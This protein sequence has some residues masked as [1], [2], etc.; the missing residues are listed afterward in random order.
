MTHDEVIARLVADRAVFD[1]KVGA[2]L[3]ERLSDEPQGHDHSPRD[4]VFHVGAYEELIVE[5]LRSARMGETTVLDRDRDGWEAFNDRV[6]AE[7]AEADPADMLDRSRV[8]FG[9]LLQEVR[10]LSDAELVEVTGITEHI[11]PAWLDG[12]TLAELIALD[13][14][15]HYRMHY[16]ALEAAATG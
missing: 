14:F 16:A 7:A 15:D 12:R 8:I 2:I 10:K 9:D 6:W 4:I 13:G 1:A 3:P 5:R 11:D